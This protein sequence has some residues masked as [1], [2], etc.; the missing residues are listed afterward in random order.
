[1]ETGCIGAFAGVVA[2]ELLSC[3]SIWILYRSDAGRSEWSHTLPDSRFLGGKAYR[4]ILS[5]SVPL[6][7]SSYLQFGAPHHGKRTDS[8][9]GCCSSA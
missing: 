3:L 8:P 4:M 6:A 1:M 9:S 5:L 7:L 2:G